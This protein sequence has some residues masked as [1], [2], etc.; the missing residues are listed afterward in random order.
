MTSCVLAVKVVME[1]AGQ[2]ELSRGTACEICQHHCHIAAIVQTVDIEAS[3]KDRFACLRH[4]AELC[5][6]TKTDSVRCVVWQS[7]ERIDESIKAIDTYFANG[8]IAQEVD[9]TKRCSI[10]T[11]GGRLIGP[12]GAECFFVHEH[13]LLW[14]RKA[15]ADL[16]G[17]MDTEDAANVVR[18]GTQRRCV[19]CRGFGAT[20]ECVANQKGGVSTACKSAYHFE[21][22]NADKRVALNF[23]SY[24]CHC[25]AHSRGR[26]SA[27]FKPVAIP[28]GEY[29]TF[30][31][32]GQ[33]AA[34][35]VSNSDLE[36][37]DTKNSVMVFF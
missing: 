8:G 32:D 10:C 14:S 20:V 28:H 26:P 2:H 37:D 29:L 31:D 23:L 21:C 22:A 18:K 15:A 30:S 34:T 19:K 24:R 17:V 13:C 33:C 5:E 9:A 36:E 16:N 4:G 12:F 11:R 35:D 27:E 7:L 1:P 25:T 6:L 3:R